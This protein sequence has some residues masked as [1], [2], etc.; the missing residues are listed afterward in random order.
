M[1]NIQIDPS[2]NNFK[3]FLSNIEIYFSN[4]EDIITKKRNTIKVLE[5]DSFKVVAKSFKIPNLINKFVYRFMRDSKAK[6]SFLN[7][8]R[9]IK[10]GVNTPKPIGYVEF[11]NPLLGK[12]FYVCDYFDY[13]FEIRAVL[14]DDNFEDRDNIFRLFAK[15]SYDLHQ[16]GIY[17][18]DFSPGNVLIKKVDKEEYKF[19][20]VDVNRMKFVEFDDDLRFENL[21]RFSATYEDTKKIASY[22]AKVSDIDMD[23]AV[24]KLLYFHDRH[25]K[26]LQNKKKLKSTLKKIMNLG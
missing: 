2:F 4:S 6:R 19:S 26:Y 12:S 23:V 3:E 10:L 22:Y 20:I 5:F 8:Q 18:I 17:H 15:F 25:Q 7:A 13:D 16:K 24:E 11:F 9:L 21:S 1:I 14:R